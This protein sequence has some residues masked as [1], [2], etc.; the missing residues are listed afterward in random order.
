MSK[1]LNDVLNAQTSEKR[2]KKVQGRPQKNIH[3]S[4]DDSDEETTL[5]DTENVAIH[6]PQQEETADNLDPEPIISKAESVANPIVD[7]LIQAPVP[8]PTVTT[9]PTPPSSATANATPLLNSANYLPTRSFH[10]TQSG[11]SKKSDLTFPAITIEILFQKIVEKQTTMSPQFTLTKEQGNLKEG[12]LTPIRGNEVKIKEGDNQV[13][14]MFTGK[15]GMKEAAQVLVDTFISSGQ[16]DLTIG[17]T[18]KDMVLILA[19]LVAQK[20]DAH[21]ELKVN[22]DAAARITLG[23][24]ANLIEKF[25]NTLKAEQVTSPTAK[26]LG[27]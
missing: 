18:D 5:E 3:T 22:L 1:N 10:Q 17:G 7:T 24:N 27:M 26:R 9:K 25:D 20:L 2:L 11:T 4:D 14:C 23:G 21:P 16:T 12:K 19:N 6:L 15:N 8:V 13:T